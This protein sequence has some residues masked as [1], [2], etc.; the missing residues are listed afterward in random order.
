MMIATLRKLFFKLH[1]VCPVSSG[2]EQSPFEYTELLKDGAV[3]L[4]VPTSCLRFMEINE[5][6]PRLYVQNPDRHL[7]ISREEMEHIRAHKHTVVRHE[8][9]ELARA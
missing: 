5:F 3:A 7:W 6:M 4:E 9:K 2:E 1:P 8:H